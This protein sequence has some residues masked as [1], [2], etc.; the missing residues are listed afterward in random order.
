[1]GDEA[2]LIPRL[3]PIAQRVFTTLRA[4]KSDA[5]ANTNQYLLDLAQEDNDMEL[6]RLDQY[7]TQWDEVAGLVRIDWEYL[8]HALVLNYSIDRTL[9]PGN[10][11]RLQSFL[12]DFRLSSKRKINPYRIVNGIATR[13]GWW[14]PG[15]KET[16]VVLH[17]IYNALERN[18]RECISMSDIKLA[19]RY[20]KG[21][22]VGVDILPEIMR[23]LHPHIVRLLQQRVIVQ[24]G[25]QMLT[26][27]KIYETSK[28]IATCLRGRDL[29]SV[30]AS[31]RTTVEPPSTLSPEQQAVYDR[32]VSADKRFTYVAAKGGRGKSFTAKH[33]ARA[34]TSVFCMAPTH[35]ALD[36]CREWVDDAD[37]DERGEATLGETTYTFMTLHSFYYR[38]VKKWHAGH[39]VDFIF[40]RKEGQTPIPYP[41]LIIVDEL[42]MLTGWMLRGV[43][44]FARFL[45]VPI[46]AFGDNSQ[47][48]CVADYGSGI[49]DLDLFDD[50]RLDL[51]V[52]YRARGRALSDFADGI[53][54]GEY[55][56]PDDP[57]QVRFNFC[58]SDEEAAA[59]IKDL[60]REFGEDGG[61][62]TADPFDPDYMQVITPTHKTKVMLNQVAQKLYG[63]SEKKTIFGDADSDL[64]CCIDDP[65]V[66]RDNTKRYKR[67]QTGVLIQV[68]TPDF[69][70]I[71]KVE[72]DMPRA[73]RQRLDRYRH[74][75][76]IQYAKVR[77]KRGKIVIVADTTDILPAYAITIHSSQ[78]SQYKRV[79]V[80]M[81]NTDEA[82]GGML[83]RKM[84]YTAISR[85]QD[86]VCF[87]GQ[88]EE[89]HCEGG[90]TSNDHEVCHQ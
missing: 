59:H 88:P 80:V 1:M 72:G 67:G 69:E 43:L 30:P 78:A 50:I 20:R 16:L 10:A 83:S 37:I 48:P 84:L 31:R 18:W 45:H 52:N 51:T 23:D 77:T 19:M 82:Y 53:S 68:Y 85:A 56:V 89:G 61:F 74:G 44:E 87:I 62:V 8:M 7:L 9:E 38:F 66:F 90:G 22:D 57:D 32:V 81:H 54:Q 17:Y 41:G 27:P 29:T 71:R 13:R 15:E 75:V 60:Y 76:N 24:V 40:G 79:A 33:C 65:V 70:E 47:L 11:T 34:F 21:D 86:F 5:C 35:K 42:S 14:Q 63:T 28:A 4:R 36:N 55:I 6:Q 46:A 64:W 39:G 49:T 26:I 2:A 25:G 58:T 3:P 73:K 12:E